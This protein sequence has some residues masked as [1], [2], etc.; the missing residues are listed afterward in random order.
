MSDTGTM[1]GTPS[2]DSKLADVINNTNWRP[3][4][5]YLQKQSVASFLLNCFSH[6]L[7]ICHEQ[8]VSNDLPMTKRPV[9][10]SEWSCLKPE[11]PSLIGGKWR[12]IPDIYWEQSTASCGPNHLG[13]TDPRY[14]WSG[15]LSDTRSQQTNLEFPVKRRALH[16]NL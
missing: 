12:I 16:M 13:Q 1:I 7:R 4:K 3:R 11:R 10:A 6:P 14:W 5:M 15:N 9:S 8:I 2:G